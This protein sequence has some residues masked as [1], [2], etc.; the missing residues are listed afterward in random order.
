MRCRASL[1]GLLGKAPFARKWEVH[2]SAVVLVVLGR[3][4][5]TAVLAEP[6]VTVSV[7]A[8]I[9]SVSGVHGAS[10]PDGEE[11]GKG[12]LQVGKVGE[13]GGS[14]V[15]CVGSEED[16][17]EGVLE[18]GESCSS[19]SSPLPLSSATSHCCVTAFLVGFAGGGEAA[20]ESAAGGTDD[21]AG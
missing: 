21:R 20:G 14:G 18:R 12:G 8:G 11:N 16:G 10:G 15:G 3:L 19:P 1:S 5:E 4:V 2:Q 7:V 17:K 9:G 6:L 13:S